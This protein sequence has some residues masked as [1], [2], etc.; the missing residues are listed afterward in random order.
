MWRWKKSPLM[1]YLQ[2]FNY[3]IGS[4]TRIFTTLKEVDDNVILYG[5]IAGFILNAVLAAQMVCDGP[6]NLFCG[7]VALLLNQALTTDTDLLLEGPSNSLT[8]G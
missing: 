4:M 8:C 5:Y 7:L 2:V 3:L 1:F 6:L